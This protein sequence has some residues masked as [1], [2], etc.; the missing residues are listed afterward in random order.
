M[1]YVIVQFDV[2]RE[3]REAFRSL[4]LRHAAESLRDEL[5]T[6]LF[7]IVQDEERP[8]RFYAIEGYADRAAHE[9]HRRGPIL[10]RIGPAVAPLLATAPIPL[11]RGSVLDDA[12]AG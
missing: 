7:R 1:Y 3:R 5:G 10:A 6:L 9:A 2:I 8:D 4:A 11:V 12:D